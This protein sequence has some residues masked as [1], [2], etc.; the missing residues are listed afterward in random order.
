MPM[1]TLPQGQVHYRKI[2]EGNNHIVLLH[3]N[4]GDSK[5]YDAVL[6]PLRQHYSVITLDWPGY[7]TSEPPNPPEQASAGL[8]Y[9]IL[10]SFLD[11]LG[12]EQV[13]LI[14]NSVGGY[15]A[16]RYAIDFPEKVKG[17]VLVSPAGFTKHTALT[18]MF[19]KL[20]SS[21]FAIT[22]AL[23]ARFYLYGNGYVVQDMH[24]RAKVQQSEPVARSINKSVWRSFLSPE[25]SL[26]ASA[27]KI[28]APTL[29][30]FGEHDP[31]VPA[32]T[33]GKNAKEVMPHAELLVSDSGHAIFAEAPE[34]F[35]SV[36]LR[37]L[38][39]TYA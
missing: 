10:K 9:E 30:M 21:S 14:G 15:A 26:L 20:Q 2:G 32:K 36:V 38:R 17:L 34:Y 6:A 19:C 22:P 3:A 24:K 5:D 31:L 18:R 33:D 29:L 28:T 35:M 8:Y 27:Q 39:K 11:Q 7:G 4:P 16:A 25:F 1:M 12:L 37:F 13:V 23:L